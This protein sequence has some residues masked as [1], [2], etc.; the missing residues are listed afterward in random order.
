MYNN[1][2]RTFWIHR[3]ESIKPNSEKRVSR[4]V[5]LIPHR[6]SL[7]P[8]EAYRSRLF[9]T[10]FPGAYAFPL[11]APLA[12]VSR[13]FSRQELKELG[14]NIRKAFPQS[15]AV[16]TSALVHCGPFTFLGVP[17]GFSAAENLFP[18]SAREKLIAILSS[19]VLCATLVDPGDNR[20]LE[21]GPVLSFRAAFLANLAIRPLPGG[22]TR[23]SFEWSIGPPVW[24]PKY[25]RPGNYRAAEK[26]SGEEQEH[27][28]PV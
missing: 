25:A 20:S 18:H 13:A 8:F 12:S 2:E 17:F 16:G 3:K 15:S 4:F 7:K 23:Y 9:A 24:L 10:G 6:D 22:D 5:I 27:F 11:A 19:P 14:G 26:E 21:A 28:S 1:T